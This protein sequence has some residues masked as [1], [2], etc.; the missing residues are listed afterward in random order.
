MGGASG[1]CQT[2]IFKVGM[3]IVTNGEADF[4]LI[5][6]MNMKYFRP[7]HNGWVSGTCLT[8]IFKVG[9]NIAT[10]GEV[11]FV[12]KKRPLLE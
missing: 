10:N 9:M 8:P 6:N 1:T 3:N 5:T 12:R 2:P 7:T 11:D 4:V